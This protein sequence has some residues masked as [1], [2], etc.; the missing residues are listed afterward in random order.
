MSKK[1]LRVLALAHKEVSSGGELPS[2]DNIEQYET[3]LTLDGIFGIIDPIRPDVVEAVQICQNAGIFVRMVTGDNIETAK[4]IATSCG[5][6]TPG[7]IAMEGPEFRKLTPQQLDDILPNL[8]VLARSS[9]N[10]KYTLVCRLNGHN[11]PETKEEWEE[12]HPTYSYDDHKDI[13]L[14]GYLDE[15]K[16]KRIKSGGVGEVVGV[17]GDGT[18]DGPALKAADVGLSMGLSGTD[19]AKDA[20]DIVILDDNFASIVKAVLW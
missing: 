17:T 14:P 2:T 4:A 7:G 13:I 10:D 1:A 19:V 16:Q 8:Q 15:W 3:E 6:L 20:S 5:I 12:L 9:P 18:N 11:L